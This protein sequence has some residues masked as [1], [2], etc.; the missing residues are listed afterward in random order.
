MKMPVMPPDYEPATE[1]PPGRE[2]SPIA[3]WKT[4]SFWFGIFPGILT[5]LDTIFLMVS[6]GS[7]GPI[8]GALASIAN[9]FGGNVTAESIN[10]AMLTIAPLYAFVVAHQRRGVNQPYTTSTIKEN[11]VVAIVKQGQS[12]W[13]A[14]TQIGNQ[15]KSHL[16]K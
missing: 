16:R 13:N 10:A 12:A 7:F 1:S 5:V 15:I 8:A 11:E 4:R 9:L 6:D 2:L 3:I 14:G